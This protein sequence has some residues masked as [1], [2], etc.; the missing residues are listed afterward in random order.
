MS[1]SKDSTPNKK[2]DVSIP[3]QQA[4][5]CPATEALR[6]H[7][8]MNV[9]CD[10]SEGTAVLHGRVRSYYLKQLAQ[11]VVKKVDAVNSVINRVD[12]SHL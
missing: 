4:N 9:H 2:Q 5:G 8:L 1:A 10:L 12:V 6:R 11:E 3:A 7:G